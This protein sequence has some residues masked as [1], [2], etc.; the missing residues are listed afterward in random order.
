MSNAHSNVLCYWCILIWHVALSY[1]RPPVA[2]GKG[3]DDSE[4]EGHT[5]PQD[6][7][8]WRLL[9]LHDLLTQAFPVVSGEL[10]IFRN[11][12]VIVAVAES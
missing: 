12:F 9:S 7:P 3:D 8:D 1:A 2:S 6:K 10:L 5:L 4:P 11:V